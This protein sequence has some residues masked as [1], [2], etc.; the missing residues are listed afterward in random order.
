MNLRDI[1]EIYLNYL[2][3]KEMLHE[4]MATFEKMDNTQK[5]NT[6]SE[7]LRLIADHCENL[8]NHEAQAVVAV[9]LAAHFSISLPVIK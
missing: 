3:Y 8:D 4:N 6:A 7:V 2:E 1:R 9:R 5:R